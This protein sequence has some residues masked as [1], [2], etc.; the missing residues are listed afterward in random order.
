ML[1]ILSGFI[2]HSSDYPG[3]GAAA[4]LSADDTS[5]ASN[6][7]LLRSRGG[8]AAM[9]RMESHLVRDVG[10]KGLGTRLRVG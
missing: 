6:L 3:S 7:T 10:E 4:P 2:L 8:V 5:S 9:T 1:G